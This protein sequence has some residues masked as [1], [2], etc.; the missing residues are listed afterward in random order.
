MEPFGS[1]SITITSEVLVLSGNPFPICGMAFCSSLTSHLMCCLP[2]AG[3]ASSFPR[4]CHALVPGDRD[5]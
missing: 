5:N 2:G 3:G 1:E 4:G